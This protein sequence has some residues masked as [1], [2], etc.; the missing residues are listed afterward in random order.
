MAHCVS[1]MA[2]VGE[3]PWHGLGSSLPSGQS[4]ETWADKAGMNWQIKETPVCFDVSSSS[5][6]A[7][8]QGDLANISVE[9]ICSADSVVSFEA[10]AV[11]SS[12]MLPFNEH[13]VLYRSDC[14]LPLSVVSSRYKVV[15]P[16]EVLEFYRDLTQQFGFELETAGV[17]K[18][19]RK[20]WALARTG[21]SC[22]LGRQDEVNGY[23][24]LAT[25]CDGS[26]AT[27]VTPTTV[28]VVCQNT[29]S[30][31]VNNTVHSIRVPHN[32]HFNAHE[33]KS[34]LNL[35]TGHWDEFM[36]MMRELT[37][38][39]VSDRE[40]QQF[41]VDVL[42]PAASLVDA[43]STDSSMEE[44]KDVVNNRI[45][46]DAIYGFS[47]T[48][49]ISLLDQVVRN[50]GSISV[51]V[52]QAAVDSIDWLKMPN[53]RAIKQV[54]QLYQGE[55]RGSSFVSAKGTAWGL[56]NAVTEFVDHRR[57]AKNQENRLDSAWFGLG[58]Q[59]KQQAL[60]SVLQLIA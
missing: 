17:L 36:L 52:E 44:G 53:G 39:R 47:E 37:R 25:S 16:L 8:D 7:V 41:M 23:V 10:A 6:N 21:Q 3:T 1:S 4:I 19:G 58:A 57:R 29:L 13:K 50:T 46:D 26:L 27:T 56:L 28:R 40:A 18:Q 34:R 59:L 38:R 45:G 51:S 20:F 48:G 5:S 35:T 9:G 55:G 32:T 15:Q 42:S 11:L 2:Y 49:E 33:V 30:V 24:L 31:A 60:S 43:L 14:Q 12:A 54:Q 22:V